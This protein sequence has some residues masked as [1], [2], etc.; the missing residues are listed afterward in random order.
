MVKW[1]KNDG[2]MVEK[3][4]KNDGKMMEKCFQGT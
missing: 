1:W 2:K 4:W 3:W